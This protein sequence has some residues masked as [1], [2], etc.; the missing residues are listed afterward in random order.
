M[1]NKFRNELELKIGKAKILLRPTFSNIAALESNVGG[2]SYLAWKFSRGLREQF[3]NKD[4]VD[5]DRTEGAVK[6][7]PTI[8]E[9]AQIIYYCQAAHDPDEKGKPLELEE[10]FKMIISQGTSIHLSAQITAFIGRMLAGD[11]FDENEVKEV[12][13][14]QKKS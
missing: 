8:T 4:K 3:Q 6:S 7:L 1:E 11:K 10:I 9:V 12:T 5:P 2:I 13:E 14:E